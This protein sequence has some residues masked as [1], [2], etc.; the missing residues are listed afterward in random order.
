[1]GAG[2]TGVVAGLAADLGGVVEPSHAVAG[3][4]AI[5]D[6]SGA[7]AGQAE[8]LAG[9][10]LAGD[11][12]AAAGL[13]EGRSVEVGGAGAARGGGYAVGVDGACYAA[14]GSTFAGEALGLALL[15]GP[16]ASV[17]EAR[18]AGA[19]VVSVVGHPVLLK[20]AGQATGLGGAG[21]GQAGGVAVLAGRP[22]QH[23]PRGADA[24]AVAQEP[25]RGAAQA[26]VVRVR[27]ASAAGPVA[28][29]ALL[30]Q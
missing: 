26:A 24:L 7:G 12:A 9:A 29:D 3:P 14:T 5:D 27:R 17:V 19:G 2:R 16:S 20:V 25:T 30:A 18:Q 10:G 4:F 28:G 23:L 13:R 1:M 22:H 11:S 21:T 8:E 15:A 6:P